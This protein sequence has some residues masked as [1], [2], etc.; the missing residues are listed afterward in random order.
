MNWNCIYRDTKSIRHRFF[1]ICYVLILV[2]LLKIICWALM[3][4]EIC[5][6]DNFSIFEKEDCLLAHATEKS[7]EEWCCYPT[8]NAESIAYIQKMINCVWFHYC[9]LKAARKNYK[10]FLSASH[11]NIGS[12]RRAQITGGYLMKLIQ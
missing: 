2:M 1:I 3:I 5:G 7:L 11:I 6:D 8:Q 10:N 9:W 4:Q 12:F